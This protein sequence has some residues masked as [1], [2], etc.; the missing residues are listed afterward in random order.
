MCVVFWSLTHPE[1]ALILCANRDEFLGRP[2]LPAHFHSFEALSQSVSTSN[3]DGPA[4]QQDKGT[5][6]VLSGRDMLAGGTWLG[7]NRST[8]R[9]AVITNITEPLATYASSRGTLVSSFLGDPSGDLTSDA[10]ALTRQTTP[11]AGFNLLLLEPLASSSASTYTLAYDARLVSNGGGGGPIHARA[12]TDAERACGGMSN[13]VDGHGGDLWPKVV[14][15]RDELGN[16]L[17]ELSRGPE[18]EEPDE[19][20]RLA[21]RLIELLTCVAHTPIPPPRERAELKNTIFVPVL[22]AGAIKPDAPHAYYGTRLAQ[23]VLVR[24]NGHVTYIERDV[25]LL[26]TTGAPV[27]AGATDLRA[28]SF[29]LGSGS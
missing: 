21:G 18:M 14:Q 10:A 28:F 9:I 1:Y 11:Y 7:I 8:G 22:D 19:D 24:R 20:E 29:R 2:T 15:G 23:V 17:D 27:R 12:P 5:G 3:V 16:V 13:G 4:V 25:W 26:D 6:S